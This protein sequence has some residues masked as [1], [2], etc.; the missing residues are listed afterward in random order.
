MVIMPLFAYA[1][2]VEARILTFVVLFCFAMLNRESGQYVAAWLIVSGVAGAVTAGRLGNHASSLR[3]PIRRLFCGLTMVGGG[4]LVQALLKRLLF[5]SESRVDPQ[6]LR[7]FGDLFWQL[8]ANTHALT[9]WKDYR[10]NLALILLV[11][12]LALCAWRRGFAKTAPVT[13]LVGLMLAT[14]LMFARITETRV[15][16]QFV[17]MAVLCAAYIV[18]RDD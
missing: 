2:F 10:A 18:N 9:I 13:V 12:L 14:T 17:P 4:W 15:W 3:K 8:P 5:V 11:L 1:I 6:N 7:R 16:F